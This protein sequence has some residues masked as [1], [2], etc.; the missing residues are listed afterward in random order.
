MRNIDLID[1]S[2]KKWQGIVFDG[3]P[4]RGPLDCP[5]CQQYHW[6]ACCGC[7][8]KEYTGLSG[9]VNTPYDNFYQITKHFTR[10]PLERIF[11]ANLELSF[12]YELRLWYINRIN[13]R[14]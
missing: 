8:I 3:K 5:L 6:Y 10:Q 7:P 11:A 12:L 1:Q 13:Q 9:C 4:D 14:K 2:I